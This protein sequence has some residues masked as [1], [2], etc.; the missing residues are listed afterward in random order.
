MNNEIDLFEGYAPGSEDLR[1]DEERFSMTDEKSGL[2]ND[3]VRKVLMPKLVPFPAEKPSGFGVVVIPGGGYRRQVLTKEG[4][5]ITAWL[6]SLGISA[7]VLMHRMP[8]DGH[9][10]DM[11]VPLQDVQRAIRLLRHRAK[12]YGLNRN[13]VGVM[14][15]SAGG[16]VAATLATS[17]D[18]ETYSPRDE[19]DKESTRPD[20]AALIYPV[21]SLHSYAI[22]GDK[23]P[24][25][26][27]ERGDI[28]GTFPTDRLIREDSPRTFIVGADD[29]ITTPSENCVNY[30][31]NLRQKGI[32]AEM[33]IFRNGGHGFGLGQG[34]GN[35]GQWPPLFE[36]WLKEAI[37]RGE[38]D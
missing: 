26:A 37:P 28:I 34:R 7:F 11:Q 8:G 12:E 19:I 13:K 24:Q 33:H 4:I 9:K 15:F 1:W 6:N 25:H 35:A 30:Y 29:D 14:G 31:L 2:E 5:R 3:Y 36:E 22:L 27:E 20:F 38:E 16:H 21:I 10:N 23:L 18:K 17:W 32:P